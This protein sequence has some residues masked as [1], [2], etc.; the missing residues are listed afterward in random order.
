MLVVALVAGGVSTTLFSWIFTG[1]WLPWVA[2]SE[3]NELRDDAAAAARTAAGTRDAEVTR[4]A[5][6]IAAAEAAAAEAAAREAVRTGLLVVA[7]LGGVF[8]LVVAYRRQKN[9]EEHERPAAEV[10]A[11]RDQTRLF[12]ERFRE[13]AAQL[14]SKA[15]A[16]RLAGVYAMAALA[17]EWAQQQQQ[18]IDV[19]CGYLRTPPRVPFGVRDAAEVEVRR[20]I[21]SV[22]RSHF[23][24]TSGPRWNN[25]VLDMEGAVVGLEVL[26]F[27]DCLFKGGELRFSGMNLSGVA[28]MSFAGSVF[29][30]AAVHLELIH[31]QGD[32]VIDFERVRVHGGRISMESL[33]IE[34]GGIRFTGGTL[35]NASL[36]FNGLSMTGGYI[37]FNYFKMLGD[38]SL[39]QFGQG[40]RHILP[41]YAEMTTNISEFLGGQV[42]FVDINKGSGR[43]DFTNAAFEG[44]AFVGPDYATYQRRPHWPDRG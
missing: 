18:C 11:D 23:Q 2:V 12:T 29:E 27:S 15:A 35:Y 41:G 5:L 24:K 22:I 9:L 7:C 6:T 10:Q 37:L 1:E 44:T 26:D 38:S 20:T 28:K 42:V 19:L 34:S 14:G 16:T 25:V 30:H 43:V 36:L 40:L 31:V 21:M 17:D 39:L 33:S 3:A 32:T 13:A 4:A 8:G